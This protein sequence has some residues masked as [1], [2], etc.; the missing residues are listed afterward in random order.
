MNGGFRLRTLHTTT[1]T[2]LLLL[3]L[4]LLLHYY[5]NNYYYYC[6]CC[7]L[8]AVFQVYLGQSVPLG[9]SSFTS[10]ER[11]PLE[12]SGMGFQAWLSGSALVSINAV[13]LRRARLVLGWVTVCGRINHLSLAEP[14]TQLNSA[15]YPQRD[16]KWEPAKVRWRSAAGEQRQ[17][18]FISLVDKRVGGR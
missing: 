7:C 14:A 18:W 11:E 16:G 13:T 8:T 1:T 12:I 5:N 2:A 17:V 4:L 6:C 10:F 15:F 9:S 3:L